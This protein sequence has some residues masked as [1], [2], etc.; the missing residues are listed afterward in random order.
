MLAIVAEDHRCSVLTN[1]LSRANLFRHG[2]AVSVSK[3]GPVRFSASKLGNRQPDQ[4]PSY[5]KWKQLQL[6]FK[7]P[8]FCSLDQS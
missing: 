8:V 7:R 6:D 4:L 2:A 5:L 1:G 3:S